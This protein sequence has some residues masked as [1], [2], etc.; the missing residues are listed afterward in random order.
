MLE[1]FKRFEIQ[2]QS[3]NTIFGGY[4]DNKTTTL[5][6]SNFNITSTSG[7]PGGNSTINLRGVGSIK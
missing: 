7:Q 2:D 1:K 3:K 5:T 6:T 4:T